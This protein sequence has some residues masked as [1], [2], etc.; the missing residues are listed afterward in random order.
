MMPVSE[1]ITTLEGL[2]PPAVAEHSRWVCSASAKQLDQRFLKQKKGSARNN[3][4]QKSHS[5]LWG[6]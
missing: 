1:H 5:L 3:L 4:D 2:L 6:K